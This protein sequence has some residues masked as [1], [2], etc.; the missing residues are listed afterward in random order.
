[1]YYKPTD[2]HTYLTYDSSHPPTCKNSI[3]Y[4]QLLRLRRICS[5]DGD[6]HD[7]ADEMI[8]F[9]HQRG[10][11]ST[12][13]D[14]ARRR[15]E[16][17][18]QDQTLQPSASS[19]SGRVPL[20]VTYHPLTTKITKI[21]KN[22]YNILQA[23]N[24]TR[25]IFPDPPLCAFRRDSNIRDQLVHSTLRTNEIPSGSTTACK[26]SRCNTCAHV[27][28]MDSI[29]GPNNHQRKICDT[30]TC[31]SRNL[32][33]AIICVKCNLIY[34]GETKRRMADRFTEHLRSIRLRM[35][36]LPIA[37]H[38]CNGH[39][40]DDIKVTGIKLCKGPDHIRKDTEQR[41]IYELGTVQPD[42]LNASFTSFK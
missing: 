1:M 22:N 41:I 26:R 9:F 18:T 35:P 7:K 5:E 31:T 11:P 14:A 10:Y 39:S 2:A 23:D 21:V 15:I 25:D 36:G 4:S 34:I 12:V 38:F 24:S 3:P 29:T 20:V 37:T 40:T 8:N 32:I 19:A 30:F 28:S 42:G 16:D 33:Y 6:F 17:I 27:I 13:T